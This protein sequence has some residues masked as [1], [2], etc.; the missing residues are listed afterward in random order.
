VLGRPAHDHD[1]AHQAAAKA[2]RADLAARREERRTQRLQR[3]HA[4]GHVVA[5]RPLPDY[6]ALFGVDFDPRPAR[7]PVTADST[8]E[9][10]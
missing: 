2:L 3:A 9:G 1:P 7:G 8:A 6:D 5:I 10:M 4:D